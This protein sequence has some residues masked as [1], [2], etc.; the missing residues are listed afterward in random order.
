MRQKGWIKAEQRQT[1][2]N[3][4][5]RYYSVIATGPRR[6]HE[7]EEGFEDLIAIRDQATSFS[8]PASYSTHDVGV[9]IAGAARERSVAAVSPSFFRFF[10]AR[11]VLGRFI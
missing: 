10:D 11:P 9:G 2:N 6:L 7:E 3:Q 1:P 5:A 4:R 8:E